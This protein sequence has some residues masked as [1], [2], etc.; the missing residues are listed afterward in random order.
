MD[1]VGLDFLDGNER[2]FI[3]AE[4]GVNHNGDLGIAKK[5]VDVAV[6]AGADAVKFQTFNADDIVTRNAPKAKYQNEITSE[7]ESQYEMLKRL[8]LSEKA[9]EILLDYCKKNNIL[10]M[11]TP[12]DFK[13]VDLLEKLGVEIYKVS[14]GDLT[15]IPLL[16]YIAR[17]EKPMIVSTGMANLGE[18][19]EAVNAIQ[20]IGNNRLILLH[21]VS[22][23]PA[24]YE[25][26]NLRAIKTL[27]QAFNLPVGYSDH[28]LG[29]EVSIAAV[30]IGAKVIEKH[31]T[32]DKNMK[33]PDHRASLNPG[34]LKRMVKS[35]RN[36]EKSFGYTLKSPA[37]GEKEN[38]SIVRKGIFLNKDK[39]RGEFVRREDLMI[40]RPGTGIE[41]RYF[42]LIIGM[43]LEKDK[44]KDKSLNWGDFKVE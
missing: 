16:K 30:A 28:T 40:K 1:K 43:R 4:A 23:Y 38:I 2:T 39:K 26:I 24:A 37:P 25:D 34:E 22:N 36:I 33:G 8:E 10:F 32:L 7:S 31:F 17:I 6:N 35:I 42:D 12:F 18:V 27:R 29:I 9:H 14:S 20:G 21:C 11:S 13:S 44:S 19:E 15:N 3:I 41:P 5:L